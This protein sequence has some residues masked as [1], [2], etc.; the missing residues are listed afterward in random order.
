MAYENYK[1]LKFRSER[2]VLFVT[3]NNPPINLLTYDLGLELFRFSGEIL[4]DQ[5]TRVIV[6][7]SANPEFFIAHFDVTFLAQYPDQPAPKTA[8]LHELNKVHETFR[9][10]PKVSIGKIEGRAR[11]GGSEFLL[12]LDMRFGAIGKAIFGQPEVALGIIPGGGGTQRLPRL[13]GT[14][15]AL[16][17]VMGCGDLSAEEAERYGYLNRALPPDE[18]AHFVE[19]LA[20]RIAS[21]PAETI[22]LAKGAVRAATELPL[23]EGLLEET[24]LFNQSCALPVAKARMK[25]FME[26]GGQTR[27]GELDL[28]KMFFSLAEAE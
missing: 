16:E 15:R 4:V 28:P 21:F 6:F 20:F 8:D 13:V 26:L 24:W 10:I 17:I 9:R 23:I 27:E 22:A 12:G 5:E 14:A 1:F 7:D 25:K 19:D 2:G 11:G 18:L 3:I